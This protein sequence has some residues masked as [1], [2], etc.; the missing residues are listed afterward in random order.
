M[1]YVLGLVLG[2]FPVVGEVYSAAD[3]FLLD[4][5]GNGW[6]PSHFVDTKLKPFL[7][8]DME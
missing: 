4:K 2:Q 5:L 3:T 8:T 1:R 6:R 7:D